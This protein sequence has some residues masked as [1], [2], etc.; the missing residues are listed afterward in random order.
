M[1]LTRLG[2]SLETFYAST[3]PALR[4]VLCAYLWH[5][6]K[7]TRK[8]RGTDRRAGRVSLTA[9]TWAFSQKQLPSSAVKFVLVAL[10]D[11]ADVEG[12]TWPCHR[13]I[14]D[15][16]LLSRRTIIWALDQ[17]EKVGLIFDT[18]TR[19]GRTHQVKIY[20]LKG[21]SGCT[22][23]EAARV[24]SVHERVQST[25]G[26]GAVAAHGTQ[27]EPTE[28]KVQTNRPS[29]LEE[30]QDFFDKHLDLEK[31]AEHFWDHFQSNGWKVG[32][33]APMRDWKAAARNW[34]RNMRQPSRNGQKPDPNQLK[35]DKEF[36]E[37]QQRLAE[38]KREQKQ[39][40]G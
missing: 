32:G 19:H 3:S 21:C 34:K 22:S 16:T 8:A 38:R 40:S 29:S 31:E 6:A 33:R 35:L 24:Q 5:H 11:N 13:T 18:G 20:Q 37:A 1:F 26:K 17:L 14:A 30:V 9:I 27:R 15:K 36:E 7:R 4:S 10:A 39:T 23:A 12:N 25:H 28:P 2:Q